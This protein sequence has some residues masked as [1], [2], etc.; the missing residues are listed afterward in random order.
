M[1]KSNKYNITDIIDEIRLEY[2][3]KLTEEKELFINEIIKRF[4]SL[5]KQKKNIIKE[6]L[7]NHINAKQH[8]NKNKNNN[9]NDIIV[10]EFTHCGN[11]FFKDKY[12]IWNENS[13]IV[14]Q[15]SYNNN[16]PKNIFYDKYKY[17][18][19]L[20]FSLTS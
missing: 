9:K 5:T 15:I 7:G 19:N 13:E 3:Q 14:G 20:S 17:N 11:L 16:I 6:F 18:K 2:K 12:N 8:D 4:P 10:T 1:S